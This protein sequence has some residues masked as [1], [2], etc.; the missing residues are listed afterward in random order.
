MHRS[1]RQNLCHQAGLDPRLIAEVAAGLWWATDNGVTGTAALSTLSWAEG[2]A[3]TAADQKQATDAKKPS[4]ISSNGAPALRFTS[5]ADSRLLTAG[6]VT[7][8]WTGGLYLALWHRMPNGTP[9]NGTTTLFSHLTASNGLRRCSLISN[10]TTNTFAINLSTDGTATQTNIWADPTDSAWHRLE[11]IFVPGSCAHFRDF[12]L[13]TPSTEA[14]NILTL[15][16]PN[17]PIAIGAATGAAVNQNDQDIGGTVL[18]LPSAPSLTDR[19]RL[20]NV[21]RPIA[22]AFA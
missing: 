19:K 15:N 10:G 16:N 8:G 17:V 2:G 22:A 4:V 14:V 3:H 5:A 9:T 12:A 6:N 13:I 18:Y 11:F 21:S 7:A 1:R 20:A